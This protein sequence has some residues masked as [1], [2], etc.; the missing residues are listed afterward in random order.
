MMVE[1]LHIAYIQS[2]IHWEDIGANLAMFEEKIWQIQSPVDLIVLPEMFSTGFSMKARELAEP[3]NSRT[4]RWM[5]QMAAQTGSV[6]MGSYIV[7]EN[8][9]FYNRLFMVYPDGTFVT[10]D[11]YHLFGLAGETEQYTAGNKR[12][13]AQVKGWRIFPQICYD[14]R[15]PV[16]SRS[17]KQP[18]NLYEYDL[19]VYVASWPKARVHAWDNLLQARAIENLTY[20]VGVNRVG[21]DGGGYEYPG[22]SL[23]I[24]YL[25]HPFN[26]PNTEEEIKIFQLEREP[27]LKF[28]SRF[29]FQQDAD[30][31]SLL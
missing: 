21:T 30:D 2:D 1:T 27:L 26:S 20:C 6:I 24:D 31:F 9:N 7:T 8:G 4:F 11:K 22:H 13:I 29:P 17:R 23:V 10:Y 25:G 14:L 5:K 12:V 19:I 15:F 18:D 16:F 28:R 3:M